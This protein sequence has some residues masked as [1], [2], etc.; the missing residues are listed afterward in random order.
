MNFHPESRCKPRLE[1][2]IS[3]GVGRPFVSLLGP[4]TFRALKGTTSGLIRGCRYGLAREA[5]RLV[6]GRDSL[7]MKLDELSH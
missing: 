6:V 7:P 3:E 2:R 4:V 5:A 1:H